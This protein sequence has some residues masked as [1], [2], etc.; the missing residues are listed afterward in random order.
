MEK[1]NNGT[2]PLFVSQRIYFMNKGYQIRT[3]TIM[4]INENNDGEITKNI[5]VTHKLGKRY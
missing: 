2:A 3:K 1:K 4:T 5:L